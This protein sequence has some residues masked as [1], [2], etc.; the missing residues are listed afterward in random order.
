MK[1]VGNGHLATH[2]SIE[3]IAAMLGTTHLAMVYRHPSDRQGAGAAVAA[4]ASAS[5]SASEE[6]RTPKGKTQR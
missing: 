3:Y 2:N 6:R 4:A 1:K 5:A